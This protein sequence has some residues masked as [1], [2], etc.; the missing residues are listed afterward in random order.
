MNRLAFAYVCALYKAFG[1]KAS[2]TT[3]ESSDK[4]LWMVESGIGYMLAVRLVE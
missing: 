1:S 2:I 3:L 4:L